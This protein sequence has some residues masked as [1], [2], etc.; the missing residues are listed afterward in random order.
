[1]HPSCINREPRALFLLIPEAPPSPSVR[2]QSAV[3]NQQAGRVICCTT[4]MRLSWLALACAALIVMAA[5][6]AHAWPVPKEELEVGFYMHSCPEAEEII[7]DAV[8]RGI[9]R[10]PGVGAGLIRMQFHDCFVRG[11]DA[12]IIIDSTLGNEA[13]KDSPA[14]NP[15]MRG[16][17]VIDDAK[18]AL[19]QH[20]PRVV[21]CADVVAFAARDGALLAGGIDYEVPAATAASPSSMR[22]STTTCPSPPATSASSLRALSARASPLT[23]WSRC[24]ART[25]SAGPTAPP[26]RSGST[27]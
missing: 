19:E 6:A 20:C 2:D 18:A 5:S 23:R 15:S 17:D 12:S 3:I 7:R 10:E 26:S 24:P 1:M 16:F 4:T 27:T 11:C 25:P 22:C 13:E 8:R 9:A 21:S 14:N